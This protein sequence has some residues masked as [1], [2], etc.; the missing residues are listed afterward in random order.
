MVNEPLL[1]VPLSIS[2]PIVSDGGASPRLTAAEVEGF[3][4]AG[5]RDR[6]TARHGVAAEGT[7]RTM[8]GARSANGWTAGR[9]RLLAGLVLLAGGLAAGGTAAAE[10]HYRCDRLD[11]QAALSGN[12]DDILSQGR[13]GWFFRAE[14]TDLDEFFVLDGES[15]SY[16]ARLGAALADRGTRLVLMPVPTRA[17]V[18]YDQMDPAVPLQGRYARRDALAEYRAFVKS[19]GA[20]GLP[21]VDLDPESIRGRI[22]PAFYLKRDLHWTPQGAKF[23]AGLAAADIDRLL[24][25]S[26]ADGRARF[27]TRQVRTEPMTGRLQS[28]INQYCDDPVP[29]QELAVFAT[30]REGGDGG[31]SDSAEQALFGDAGDG[32]PQVVLAGTSFSATPAFNFP[33]FLSEALGR[34]VLDYSISAGGLSTSLLSYLETSDFDRDP[35]AVLLWEFL[36]YHA[37][38]DD[39]VAFRQMIGA[40]NG[41]CTGTERLVAESLVEITGAGDVIAVPPGAPPL[42]G[43]AGYL[44]LEIP[45]RTVRRFTVEVEYADRDADIVTIDQAPPYDS[46]S[47]FFLEFSG[48]FS[49][50]VKSVRVRGLPEDRA[51][52]ISAS[53][54]RARQGAS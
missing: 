12:E 32:G 43:E 44:A 47:R 30:V 31:P 11:A 14:N 6:S 22:G 9:R 15:L 26:A 35:P 10:P 13:D 27:T 17:L 52:P 46:S 7:G 41:T 28:M 49:A 51:L 38:P 2:F 50:P 3:V 54:C 8:A 45:D 39:A 48:D 34:S 29:A 36:A 37:F 42:V 40:A 33:G 18:A 53:I 19:L 25:A 1:N 23:A 4:R 16:M 24:G 5:G 20:I 21:V